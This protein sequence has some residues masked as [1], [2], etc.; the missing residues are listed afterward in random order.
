MDW[1][2]NGDSFSTLVPPP[3]SQKCPYSTRN[4]AFK[5]VGGP[6]RFENFSTLTTIIV[7]EYSPKKPLFAWGDGG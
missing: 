5:G 7:P 2:A 1:L 3:Y 4:V 6:L